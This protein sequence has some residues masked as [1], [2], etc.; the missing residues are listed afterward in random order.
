MTTASRID[1]FTSDRGLQSCFAA[2][3]VSSSWATDFTG[4]HKID[5]LEDFCYL[6]RSTDWEKSLED[7]VLA[8]PSLKDNRI[9]VARFKAA[10]ETGMQAIKQASQVAK[11]SPE[12]MDEPLPESTNTQ[13]TKDFKAKYGIEL[14]PH[15]DPCDA[16]RARVYREFRKGSI[17]VLDVKKVRNIMASSVP[18]SQE[19]VSLPGGIKLEFDRDLP[20]DISSSIQY[21]FG[22][23][24]LMYA[25]SWAG[26]YV[27]KDIDG[28]DKTMAPLTITQGYADDSLRCCV[29][30]G[31]SSLIWY[32]RN[33]TLT[34]G[35]VASLVRRGH[36][37][38]SA[39][40][41]ALRQTHL[42][43]RSPAMAPTLATPTPPK[44]PAK[45]EVEDVEHPVKRSRLMKTD[46]FQT[47]SMLKGGKKICKPH[48]DGRG[49]KGNCGM[50][51]V[52]DVKLS[53]GKPC[54]SSS[55]HRL[56]HPAE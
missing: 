26:S 11:P 16:L 47:I 48:N 10:Y 51:H 35:K 17:T 4:R 24:T 21:Y 52:C 29:E 7:L 28:K 56:N 49:C 14:D 22:L 34:R 37:I 8:C 19:S 3:N 43:W 27:A 18:K 6:V 53:T 25:W 40:P 50:A 13:L 31:Q 32:Q 15:L 2:A 38:G 54:A 12:T 45:R 1:V 55:R 33:D 30:Y 46:A 42:E 41:E 20:M 44:S 39:I 5:T 9:A 23:R 36:T